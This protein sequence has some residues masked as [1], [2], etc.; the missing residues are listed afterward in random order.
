M[1]TLKRCFVALLF[2]SNSYGDSV[3]FA[4]NSV[5]SDGC[6]IIYFNIRLGSTVAETPVKFQSDAIQIQI[7]IQNFFIA[8]STLMTHK[9]QSH[10]FA[11]MR[12]DEAELIGPSMGSKQIYKLR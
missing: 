7:Q 6:S 1:F 10:I 9:I 8:T 4:S 3:R 5:T 2:Q 11:T 12:D